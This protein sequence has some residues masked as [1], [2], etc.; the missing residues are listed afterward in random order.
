MQKVKVAAS[1]IMVDASGGDPD[2]VFVGAHRLK[3]R[4]GERIAGAARLPGESRSRFH[5]ATHTIEIVLRDPELHQVPQRHALHVRPTKTVKVPQPARST[6]KRR[7]AFIGEHV[8]STL[9]D[10]PL[11]RV[12]GAKVPPQA[13]L[14][15]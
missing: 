8:Q 14:H 3:W 9:D 5:S 1:G 4:T 15:G 6:C 10:I 7:E 13:V 12:G 2:A 11:T